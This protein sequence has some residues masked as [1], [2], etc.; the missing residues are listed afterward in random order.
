MD[1]FGRAAF[2]GSRSDITSFDPMSDLLH[3]IKIF[4]FRQDEEEPNYLLLKPDQ[5]LEALWGP[6]QGALGF[7][8]KMEVAVRKRVFE[9]T[10]IV[11]QVS[12]VDLGA[13]ARWTVGDE[14][15]FEWCFGFPCLDEPDPRVLAENWAA[16][17]WASFPEAYPSL[18][19][20][21][22]RNAIM[23]LHTMLRAA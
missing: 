23:R 11:S 17:R 1:G 5:G 20:E 9:E 18:G 16:H 13:P 3:R 10:G 14:Q 8:D 22:D 7:G 6:V 4:L 21:F 12:A 2:P 19:L 15:V